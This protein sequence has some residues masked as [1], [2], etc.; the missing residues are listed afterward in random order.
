MLIIR[1]RHETQCNHHSNHGWAVRAVDS[2][3]V[4]IMI[5][6]ETVLVCL[7]VVCTY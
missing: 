1:S 3:V 6:I 7:A 2:V 4:V 5:R